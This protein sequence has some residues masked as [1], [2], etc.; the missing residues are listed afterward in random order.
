M[1]LNK[2]NSLATLAILL[3]L[4]GVPK[5]AKAFSIAQSDS[6]PQTQSVPEE[7]S[8]AEL[9]NG[10]ANENAL[11]GAD[12]SEMVADA[13]LNADLQDS[14][15]VNTDLED[16]GEIDTDL[17]DSGAVNTD[18]ENSGEA[19]PNLED[20]GK[21]LST[22]DLK[23][24]GAIADNETIVPNTAEDS[25]VEVSEKKNNWWW[26]LIP[27]L[28]IP[29]LAAII[30]LGGRRKSDREPAID[31]LPN[32]NDPDG[33]I[34]IA[35]PVDGDG[36]NLSRVGSN[37]NAS[38]LNSATSGATMA[39]GGAA[40][41]E[42]AN[43]VAGDRRLSEP[44]LDIDR[45]SE[46][47]TSLI[48][49]DI[50]QEQTESAVEIPSDSVSEFTG[51]ETQ[52]Q[53][54]EQPTTL[55]TDDELDG[56]LGEFT[57]QETQLQVSEQPT[58]LQ[59]DDELD[60]DL[61]EFTGQETQLQVSEQPTTLQTDDELDGDLGDD[62]I[63]GE[64]FPRNVSAAA[65]TAAIGGIAASNLSSDRTTVDKDTTDTV[66]SELY[67]V[68]PIDLPTMDEVNDSS[69]SEMNFEDA[70][71]TDEA[72][73][74][75]G[76]E[77]R[78]DFVLEEES[79]TFTLEEDADLTLDSEPTELA[80]SSE[81]E[82]DVEGNLDTIAEDSW[83]VADS[84]IESDP[85]ADSTIQSQ[86][87]TTIAD[88]GFELDQEATPELESIDAESNFEDEGNLDTIAEDSWGVAD[89]TVESDPVADST[90]QS[91]EA[92]TIAD[93]GFELNQEATPE[94]ESI[95]AE[96]N[97]EDEGDLGTIAEDSWGVADSTVESDPVADSTIQ[98]QETTTIADTGFELD[99]ESIPE[100]ESMDA[101]SNFDEESGNVIDLRQDN[102][103]ESSTDFSIEDEALD[104]T[105]PEMDL[106]LSDDGDSIVEPDSSVVDRATQLGGADPELF[107]RNI[108]EIQSTDAEFATEEDA[109]V[110]QSDR[111]THLDLNDDVWE[112]TAATNETVTDSEIA[113]FDG[114]DNFDF[115]S[116]LVGVDRDAAPSQLESTQSDRL[117]LADE[118]I[119]STENSND[120]D[121]T[122][123]EMSFDQT[124][125]TVDASLEEITFDE[126][127]GT[128]ELNL[129][130]IT[131]DD[132]ANTSDLTL[133]EMSFDQTDNTVDASLEEITFDEPS[134][135][136]ELNL[137]DI[138][139]DETT[140]TTNKPLDDLNRSSSDRD[141]E[142]DELDFAEAESTAPI[143]NSAS[144]LL[145]DNTADI[146]SLS[147]N[148]SEDIDN[149]SEWL[150]SL[151]TP[152]QNTEDISEWLNSL[153]ADETDRVREGRS[154]ER[155][156]ELEEADDISF[157]FLEDLLERDSDP[158]GDRQ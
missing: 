90:I 144:D 35:T 117:N 110:P 113:W 38:G 153:N 124:D 46:Q 127:S 11:A 26:W 126:S 85:V 7:L 120:E 57:G 150:E 23:L 125:N 114:E 94:L 87:T 3:A 58:T 83:G 86:E 52:L 75:V 14:G 59:T 134:S 79:E 34:G 156:V 129:E 80:N 131:F 66:K 43:V 18:W 116:D 47:T 152:K 102:R 95:D 107:E 88:T 115:T 137:E 135:T 123:E 149:I 50:D 82:S 71:T 140:N 55:Q 69:V 48:S 12:A 99:Q 42:S 81:T 143:D 54:S 111:D 31:R 45:Q 157:Q 33:G 1:L 121:L 78:G 105:A 100:L 65:G 93:T 9:N 151:E 36:G 62:E 108:S 4:V 29:L 63:L 74:T 67:S 112:S 146:T 44:D 91:Q 103:E 155:A 70:V 142:I 25:E 19:D 56:D 30:T 72:T 68:Q 119:S 27:L 96:S 28:G 132:T 84:T 51:Q 53:V 130:D 136:E 118:A 138:S 32:H 15:A 49:E 13:E 109:E 37:A 98:S 20:S 17:E 22:E 8:Q 97:F 158:N 145:S 6:A 141:I 41:A 154:D 77:F 21:P 16:S 122:L 92:T 76:R 10:I 106:S 139:F 40:L 147:D 5:S 64:G 24:E 39:A 148:D 101:E 2:H 133:E 73:E 128:E 89:S 104:R 60:G 61:G